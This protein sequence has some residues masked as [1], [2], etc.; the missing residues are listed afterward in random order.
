MSTDRSRAVTAKTAT[1]PVT[2]LATLPVILTLDDM[3]ALYRVS[4][5]TIRRKL[6]LNEFRPLPRWKY[7]LRWHRDDVQRGLA[8]PSPRLPHNNH[9]FAAVK[10]RRQAERRY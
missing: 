5:R 1:A 4:S 3:A 7:P 9:G 6:W 2:N 10:A 8:T